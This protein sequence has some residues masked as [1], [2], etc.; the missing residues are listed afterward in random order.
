MY[1]DSKL[2]ITG[3]NG[4]L[5]RAF[6][7]IIPD[8]LFA[9]RAELDLEWHAD[10]II[11]AL[12]RFNPD[13]I[14]HTA[15]YTNVDEAQI[16]PQKAAKINGMATGTLVEYCRMH[17]IPIV[18]Y[19]TD[20]VFNSSP[21]DGHREE[22]TPQP[23]SVYGVS[24]YLGELSIGA[25]EKGIAIRLSGVFGDG[26]NFVRAMLR[27]SKERDVVS[28]VSDQVMRPTY[29]PDAARATLDLLRH[30]RRDG[31]WSLPKI[32]HMQNSGIPVHWADYAKSIFFHT[33]TST[34]V[35]RITF[36]EYAASRGDK[37]TAP[38]PSNSVFNMA[39]LDSLGFPL[40]SWE[41]AL[42]EYCT[43]I[44]TLAL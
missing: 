17:G 19:S 31:K 25:Y 44:P 23:L 41:E 28:V 18:Y 37:P 15:A 30:Y 4:Q 14:I 34:R 42:A 9:S 39:L 11:A 10:A 6:R 13:A 20:Y 16:L 27:L 40:R 2:L 12:E 8:A 5:G 32:I 22:E 43:S 1:R 24:K 21:A 36:E 26:A 38:R 29:A 7:E 3:A 33:G 35:R